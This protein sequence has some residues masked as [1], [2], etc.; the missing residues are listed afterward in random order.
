MFEVSGKGDA[1]NGRS[2]RRKHL[3]CIVTMCS[4]VYNEICVPNSNSI[5]CC[6]LTYE[7]LSPDGDTAGIGQSV[8]HMYVEYYHLSKLRLQETTT[9]QLTGSDHNNTTQ[10]MYNYTKKHTSH[11]TCTLVKKR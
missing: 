7:L 5:K 4:L 1:S 11:C 8:R 9:P 10:H 3:G 2:I 6:T